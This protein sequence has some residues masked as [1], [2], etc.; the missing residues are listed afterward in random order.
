MRLYAALE[1]PGAIISTV[2]EWMMK[3]WGDPLFCLL[4]GRF[5]GD[6]PGTGADTPVLYRKKEGFE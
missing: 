2:I 1:N 4:S 3:E 6:A 5:H